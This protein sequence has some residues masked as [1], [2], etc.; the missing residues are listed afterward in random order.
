MHNIHKKQAINGE[1]NYNAWSDILTD[2]TISVYKT[3]V[4]IYNRLLLQNRFI[5][6]YGLV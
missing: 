2:Q 6:G 3:L 5:N 1:I 4:W